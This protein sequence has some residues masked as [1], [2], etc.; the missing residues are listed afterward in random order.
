MNKALITEKILQTIWVCENALILREENLVKENYN[1][2]KTNLEKISKAFS[3]S[4]I[5]YHANVYYKDFRIP[6]PGDHFSSEWGLMNRFSNP[7]SNNWIEYPR[8]VIR[9]AVMNDI[10]TNYMA[11]AH[12]ISEQV[13]KGF[14]ENYDTVLTLVEALLSEE[15]T[16]SLTRLKD[17]LIKIK[18]YYTQ[19]EIIEI[20][21]PKGEFMSRDSTAM[22]QG[23]I[24]P[25]HH[26]IEAEQIA[27]FSPFKALE[28]LVKC[29]KQLLN[30]MEIHSMVERMPKLTASKVFIGHGRSSLWR[31]LKDFLED[32]LQLDWEEFNRESTA[33]IATVER[34]QEMLNNSCF[35]FL[36]MSGEDQH[37]DEK[38]HARENVIHEVGL[39]Q[40]RLGFR[41]AIVLLEEGCSEFSNIVGLGQIRFPEGNISAVFEKIR[42]VLERE[43]IT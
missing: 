8:K 17:D 29:S 43:G 12:K 39:F 4:W 6:Q 9:D 41:K 26:I 20:L 37:A 5:G 24:F 34:L 40:G 35:A 31:E 19:N 23:F 18:G 21:R 10:D 11:R 22:S 7:M 33:G 16:T 13:K 1:K 27:L 14:D 42:K 28:E 36:V 15:E 32:R 2:L 38:L 30:Y 25:V 3:G